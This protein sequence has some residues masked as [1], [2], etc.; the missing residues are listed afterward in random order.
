[1]DVLGCGCRL[2]SIHLEPVAHE[3]FGYRICL[4][5]FGV[6]IIFFQGRLGKS[7]NSKALV[8]PKGRPPTPISLRSGQS[9][10]A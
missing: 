8:G 6:I 5:M 1:M 9:F 7:E 3:K 4:V 10:S 2:E